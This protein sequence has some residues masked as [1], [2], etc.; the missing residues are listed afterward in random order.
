LADEIRPIIEP[1]DR[2][3]RRRFEVGEYTDEFTLMEQHPL[4][5]V[6]RLKFGLHALEGGNISFEV[7]HRSISQLPSWTTDADARQ[8]R[9]SIRKIG[10][11]RPGW[12]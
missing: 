8:L 5:T 6:L 10:L 7:G 11:S 2:Y 4:M 12:R 9:L 1:L 3:R